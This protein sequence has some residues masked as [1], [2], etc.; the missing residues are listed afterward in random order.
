M[1]KYYKIIVILLLAVFLIMTGFQ[2]VFVEAD[3]HDSC[4]EK[5]NETQNEKSFCD[6]NK[7]CQHENDCNQ[8]CVMYQFFHGDCQAFLDERNKIDFLPELKNLIEEANN[9][10]TQSKAPDPPP[11]KMIT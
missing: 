3:S 4:D 7:N 8:D 11:P 2:P 1:K 10:K 5:I 9:H 6:E